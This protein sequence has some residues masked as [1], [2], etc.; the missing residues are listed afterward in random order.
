MS[1]DWTQL[2]RQATVIT[3]RPVG[4][5]TRLLQLSLAD[6][7]PFPFQPGHVVVVGNGEHRH[8]YTVCQADP[9]R[10]QLGLVFRVLPGGRM[11]PALER[12]QPGQELALSGLHHRPILEEVAPAAEAV[13]GLATGSGIGP[14]WGF[15]ASALAAG[16]SRPIQLFAGFREEADICLAAEL[17]ALQAAH[18]GFR[19]QPTLTQP[20][21]GWRGLCGRLGEVAPA[22]IPRP[23]SCH[24][25]L[26]GNGAMLAE[27]KA[28]L[29]ECGVPGDQVSSEVFFNFKAEA[30]A[31]AVREIV[32][33]FQQA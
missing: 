12:A 6:D 9:A 5:G 16:F 26:V 7:L 20:G 28:A 31:P 11:T 4:R 18:P 1:D 10:R 17:D 14:L 19:W 21:P 32:S 23:A 33:G 8:P 29:R 25:H 30:D 24:F 13:V 2:T 22:L 27:M 15:A 3:S